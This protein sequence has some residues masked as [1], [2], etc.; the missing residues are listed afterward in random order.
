[1]V[2]NAA[3]IRSIALSGLLTLA[4]IKATDLAFLKYLSYDEYLFPPNSR[5]AYKTKEFDVLVSINRFGFRGNETALS[6]GQV[7]VIGDSFTFGW[8]L[9]DD[10]AWARL[11]EDTLRSSGLELKVY[12]LGVPG[13]DTSYHL[14]VAD[15]Y[16]R[17]LKPRFVV[18]AVH[19]G[20]DLSQVLETT[21]AKSTG[22]S[23]RESARASL[24][25]WFPGLLKFYVHARH[26]GFG[27]H[28]GVR[29]SWYSRYL[30]GQ[31]VPL[32]T[33]T[34]GRDSLRIVKE[35]NLHLPDD[36]LARAAAGDINPGLL[37]SAAAA[38]APS[39]SQEFL[40]KMEEARRKVLVE[41]TNKFSDIGSLARRHGG[42]LA[43]LSLPDG[44]LVNSASTK[45]LREY[46]MKIADDDLVTREPETVL[47]QMAKK[48]DALFIPA[49][50]EFRQHRGAE[51][52]FPLD[53][54]PTPE[55]S[56]L[57]ANMVGKALLNQPTMR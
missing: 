53:G 12:N 4:V 43:I 28:V 7:L 49:L 36:M 50:A 1:M 41:L 29:D 11:L 56:R 30:A 55:G 37:R 57:V 39:G 2:K 10:E 3:S 20:E 34:W 27:S 8:G 14:E 21:L 42:R 15:R 47:E 32:V 25:Q 22:K 54:H 35:K 19:L 18:I 46:G 23:M 51:L 33:K 45:N 6:E 44:A 16:V 48:S 31:P 38:A 5:V 40:D 52:F 9:N 26:F 24:S 13:T 17:R